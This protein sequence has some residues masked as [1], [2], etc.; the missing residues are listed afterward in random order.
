[1]GYQRQNGGPPPRLLAL[2]TAV[3]P[4]PLAQSEVAAAAPALF[5]ERGDELTRLLPVYVNAGIER[6]YSCQPLADYRQ[7]ADWCGRNARYIEGAL[8]LLEAAAERCLAEAGLGPEAVDALVTVST[9]G[10]ATPSLDARLMER[11]SFRHEVERLPIFGLGCAGG[12][13]G[14]ARAAALAAG[15]PGAKVLLLVVELCA[16][17]F[18]RGDHSN[19]NIVASALFG[20]GA[21][22]ALVSVDEARA[23]EAPAITHWGE[24]TWP[25]SLEIMGWSVEND[26]LGVI[27]SQDIPTLVRRDLGAVMDAYLARHG[28]IRADIDHYVSHPGGAKVIRALEEVFG[29]QRGALVDAR[30]VLRDYG[31]MSAASVLFVLEA[32]RRRRGLGGRQLLSALG[33]GFT[34]AF[35][36]LEGP[37]TR[38]P[39]KLRRAIAAE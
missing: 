18:R 32:A 14:L 26:G 1:M 31:N 28:L 15:R 30:A 33:P 23:A 12:V 4:H 20:D 16:L 11:V 35:A 24:H 9:T 7:P 27:F 36:T 5:P 25:D 22:A 21:A 34:A 10:L 29:L 6:R 39:L 13:L 38:T 3:P 8:D 37:G 17:T 19:A 2:S